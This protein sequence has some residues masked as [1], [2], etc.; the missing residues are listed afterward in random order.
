MGREIRMVIPN[1]EHPK[2]EDGRYEPLYDKG[3]DSAFWEWARE[4]E[5][6]KKGKHPQ[7]EDYPYWEYAGGPPDPE[8]CRPDWTEKDATWV[9]MYETVSEGTP[10]TPPFATKDELVNYLVEHGDF[11]DQKRGHGGWDRANAEK[12]VACGY[13]LSMMIYNGKISTPRD[14]I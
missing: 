10:V 13:A 2:K 1:W 14:G 12:F 11:W 5:L 7:Q 9:Q 6:W 8:C 3:F 4:Y